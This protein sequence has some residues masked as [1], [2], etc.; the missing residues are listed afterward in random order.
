MYQVMFKVLRM[1]LLVITPAAWLAQAPDRDAQAARFLEATRATLKHPGRTAAVQRLE[2]EVGKRADG[3]QLLIDLT[4]PEKP[5]KGRT[6][7]VAVL[8]HGG[9]PDVIPIRAR[10]WQIYRDWGAM[11]A[12][13]GAAVVMFDH[14]LG[15]PRARLDQAMTE[16]DAVLRWLTQNAAQRGFDTERISAVTFSAGGL[17]VPALL[18]P[19]RA[20]RFAQVIMF[21]PLLGVSGANPAAATMDQPL[22]DRLSTKSA[23]ARIAA[24]GT[25]LLIFR[26]GS[27]EIP[28]LLSVLDEAVVALLAADARV[29]LANLPRAP[30]SFD[31]FTERDDVTATIEQC[32]RSVVEQR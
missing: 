32:A 9:L 17:L 12:G 10:Q 25:P 4:L 7:P 14:T 15:A 24:R 28:G 20:A 21:Y 1:L 26:A 30:H 11:L 18:E 5:A 31:M 19:A 23:A 6:L 16:T 13:A 3:S 2:L 22:I 27:D 8:F 29:E